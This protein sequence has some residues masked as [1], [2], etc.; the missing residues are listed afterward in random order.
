MRRLAAVT[1]RAANDTFGDLGNDPVSSPTPPKHVP[2]VVDLG[3]THM[4]K[5]KHDRIHL[6][7]IDTGLPLQILTQ[8]PLIP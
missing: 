6:A 2:Y 7:T 1:V 5:L 4:I 3:P 8:P